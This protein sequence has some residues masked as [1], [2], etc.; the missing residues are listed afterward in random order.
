MSIIFYIPASIYEYLWIYIFFILNKII[1]FIKYKVRK[2][3]N[4][5]YNSNKNLI[6]S[7]MK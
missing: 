3:N 4:F 7:T 2:K 1:K 5:K 6:L